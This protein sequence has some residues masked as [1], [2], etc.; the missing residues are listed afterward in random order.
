[1]HRT[2][3]LFGHPDPRDRTDSVSSTQPLNR[4]NI[5]ADQLRQQ[6]LPHIAGHVRPDHPALV[7]PR[8]SV[9]EER[10]G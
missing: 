3:S 2:V 6:P 7:H 5:H 10:I 1:M 4:R 9:E 8:V